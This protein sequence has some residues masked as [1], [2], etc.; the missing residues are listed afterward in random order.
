[1]KPGF[2]IMG[3]RKQHLWNKFVYEVSS[4]ASPKNVYRHLKKEFGDI[5][6][7]STKE[8]TGVLSYVRQINK[9]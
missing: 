1:M 6:K 7:M 8:L 5:T 2:R 3:H 4:S 9:G